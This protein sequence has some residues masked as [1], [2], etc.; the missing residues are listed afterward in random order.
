MTLDDKFN[1]SKFILDNPEL[2][3]LVIEAQK[4]IIKILGKYFCDKGARA[5]FVSTTMVMGLILGNLYLDFEIKDKNHV[6]ATMQ[7]I[8]NLVYSIIEKNYSHAI[9]IKTG[10]IRE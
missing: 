5:R 4:D 3:Q 8:K 10:E 1:A 6:E 7:T 2:G 9:N